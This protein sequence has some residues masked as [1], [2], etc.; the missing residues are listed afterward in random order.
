MRV[1]GQA[2]Q[3]FRKLAEEA[4][5]VQGAET[6]TGKL[7]TIAVGLVNDLQADR[8]ELWQALRRFDPNL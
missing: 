8:G 6:S 5:A 7:L 3:N 4:I 1:K 2:V